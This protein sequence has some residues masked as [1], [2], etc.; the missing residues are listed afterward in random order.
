[1]FWPGPCTASL[2]QAG[3]WDRLLS[4]LSTPS[5]T[6]F[7]GQG[8]LDWDRRPRIDSMSMCGWAG[9]TRADHLVQY[10][11]NCNADDAASEKQTSSGWILRAVP[12]VV[13]CSLLMFPGIRRG[14]RLDPSN[15]TPLVPAED[16]KIQRHWPTQ[17]QAPGC[18]AAGEQC[19]RLIRAKQTQCCSLSTTVA[20]DSLPSAS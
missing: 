11:M 16:T 3:N 2:Q 1:V 6:A 12:M 5:A 20:Q 10:C 9:L 17:L 13:F 18:T 7:Q 8:P 15:W 4:R 19:E 14:E